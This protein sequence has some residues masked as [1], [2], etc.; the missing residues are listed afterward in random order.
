V[1]VISGR[2]RAEL[3]ERLPSEVTHLIG[4]HGN[5]GLDDPRAAERE[6][7]CRQWRSMLETELVSAA[8]TGIRVEDK[9]ASLSLHYRAA[10]SPVAALSLLRDVIARLQPAPQVIDGKL[11]LNLLPP[12]SITKYE[13]LLA[14][15]ERER[16]EA[17]LFVGDDDTDELVFQ[18]APKHWTTVRVEP[19]GDSSARYSLQ[20]QADVQILL[21]ELLA[22]RS[23]ASAR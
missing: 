12:G 16:S 14:L 19:V 20:A 17:V 18:R 9:R 15:V 5:E 21:A 6:A 8:A 10:P 4:N 22:E 7:V 2:I 11:V 3:V 13:A 1:A 23:A